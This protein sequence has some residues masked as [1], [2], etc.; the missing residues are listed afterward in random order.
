MDYLLAVLYGGKNNIE[1]QELEQVVASFCA[2]WPSVDIRPANQAVTP[3]PKYMTFSPKAR[4]LTFILDFPTSFKVAAWLH[5]SAVV[6]LFHSVSSACQG[7]L[8]PLLAC[9]VTVFSS[10]PIINYAT[11]TLTD[12]HKHTVRTYSLLPLLHSLVNTSGF[13]FTKWLNFVFKTNSR[14]FVVHWIFCPLLTR[15]KSVCQWSVNGVKHRV[16]PNTVETFGCRGEAAPVSSVF[17]CVL[18][19][20]H[21]WKLPYL[22]PPRLSLVLWNYIQY[23]RGMF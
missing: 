22:W 9:L 14:W 15:S 2:H 19:H 5:K 16:Q 10:A 7:E 23:W 1:G 17:A 13:A 3:R 8:D 21:V 12:A 4:A 20:I 6:C 18:R 11:A